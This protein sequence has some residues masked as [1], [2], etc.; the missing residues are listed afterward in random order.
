VPE[1]VIGEIERLLGRAYDTVDV[2][3]C[4]LRP[5]SQFRLRPRKSHI[6]DDGRQGCAS[7][8]VDR[9]YCRVAHPRSQPLEALVRTDDRLIE[10][11]AAAI[12]VALHAFIAA[13]LVALLDT[14]TD[15]TADH[16]NV[17]AAASS[18]CVLIEK[19]ADAL[20]AARDQ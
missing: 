5:G 17:D 11:K 14:P 10:D 20:K 9:L 4:A 15:A 2:D 1:T 6:D 13:E 3:D 18:A 12:V 19:I 7:H 8:T 16:P